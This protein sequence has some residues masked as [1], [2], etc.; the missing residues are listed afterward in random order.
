ML[1]HSEITHIGQSTHEI[2][3]IFCELMIIIQG[4]ETLDNG[5]T[6]LCQV[7]SHDQHALKFLSC[8]EKFED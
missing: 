8:E 3:I 4:A 2:E 5:S 1:T 7:A 6:D